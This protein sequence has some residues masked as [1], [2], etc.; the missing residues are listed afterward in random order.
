MFRCLLWFVLLDTCYLV[1]SARLLFVP[2]HGGASHTKSMYPA[3]EALQ[4]AGHDVHMLQLIGDDPAEECRNK[5]GVT[6][7]VIRTSRNESKPSGSMHDT[8]SKLTWDKHATN[9]MGMIFPWKMTTDVCVSIL[10]EE[11][12]R[13]E[14]FDIVGEQ[15]DAVFVDDFF[16]TCGLVGIKERWA[17]RGV[18]I[19]DFSTTILLPF[20]LKYRG[21]VKPWSLEASFRMPKYDITNFFY[22]LGVAMD[23]LQY[24][25][26]NQLLYFLIPY[27]GQRPEF[28]S[29]NPDMLA[30]SG[31]FAIASVPTEID[32][33]QA[34]TR[35]IAYLD[36]ACPT[37]KLIPDSFKTYIEDPKSRGTILFAMGHYAD[38]TYAPPGAI[39][40][41]VDAFSRLS[42]YRIIW[43]FAS[44]SVRPANVPSN[45]RMES[46]IPQ[47]AILSHPKTK[48][49]ISHTG[50]K[51]LREAVCAKVPTVAMPMFAEQYRNTAIVQYRRFGGHL[52]KLNLTKEGVYETI[53]KVLDQGSYSAAVRRLQ[54]Q[55]SDRLR[56]PLDML[57]FDLDFFLRRKD[58]H[59]LNRYIR[60]RWKRLSILTTWWQSD[61]L[62]PVL[63]IGVLSVCFYI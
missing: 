5:A 1:S 4:R 61:I 9:P 53:K 14:F 51:S 48:L 30:L 37:E 42:D 55:M 3:A 44:R 29:I 52:D 33:S 13:K 60:P 16:A 59:V 2:A 38:W 6:D 21:V 17:A 35:D 41:F 23:M 32:F 22:R 31:R 34:R 62:L 24:H 63:I 11:S 40:A 20:S 15:W 46:W 8:L 36:S 57:V 19:V 10:A 43:Q 50:L 58:D 56:D 45:V 49:F 12:T 39:D 47:Y 26:A 18:V 54:D 28:Q 27:W 7:R 25:I